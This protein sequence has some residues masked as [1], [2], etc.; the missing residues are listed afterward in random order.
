MPVDK[1]KQNLRNILEKAKAKKMKVLICGMLAPSSVGLDYQRD[2]I[3]TFGELSK[4]YD[5]AFLPF[6][7]TGVALDKKLNQAD[8]IH[9]NAEGTKIMTDNIYEKLKPLLQK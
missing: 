6:M 5:T 1:M 3:N 8:G 4:E 2:F 7:L 9:P